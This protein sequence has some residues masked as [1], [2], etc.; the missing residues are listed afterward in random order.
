[1]NPSLLRLL[2]TYILVS[3]WP[4]L[5]LNVQVTKILYHLFLL[6]DWFRFWETHFTTYQQFVADQ[7][8]ISPSL[9]GRNVWIFFPEKKIFREIIDPEKSNFKN[10]KICCR[11]IWFKSIFCKFFP[12]IK[13]HTGKRLDETWNMYPLHMT[14]CVNGFPLRYSG[15][16]K[17]NTMQL[18]RMTH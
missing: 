5:N 10:R 9:G 14:S 1:V 18:Y 6:L 17:T 4:E 3:Y 16:A 12:K 15:E 2:N 13:L 8:A 11:I 7:S